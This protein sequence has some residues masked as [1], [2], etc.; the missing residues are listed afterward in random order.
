[1]IRYFKWLYWNI[2]YLIHGTHG[3]VEELI[4]RLERTRAPWKFKPFVSRGNFMTEIFWSGEPYHSRAGK[5]LPVILIIGEDT[6]KVIG[7]LIFNTDL[8]E[9]AKGDHS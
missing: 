2:Y 6:K 4:T 9:V 5:C 7:L 8:E 3:G 1:M